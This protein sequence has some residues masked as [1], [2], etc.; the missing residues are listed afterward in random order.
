ML[1]VSP[2]VYDENTHNFVWLCCSFLGR[3]PYYK[4]VCNLGFK[5]RFQRCS[6]KG[7]H[8]NGSEYGTITPNGNTQH[9]VSNM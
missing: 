1:M 6:R 8:E 5:V 3:R 7:G 9:F 2:Y 4:L